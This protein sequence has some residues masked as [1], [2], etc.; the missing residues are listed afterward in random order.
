M[1][2]SGWKTDK[3][4]ERGVESLVQSQENKVVKHGK[5]NKLWLH[6]TA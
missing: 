5:E 4:V 1:L 6:R 2:D 3:V